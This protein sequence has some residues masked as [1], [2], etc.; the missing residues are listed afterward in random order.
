MRGSSFLRGRWHGRKSP[1]VYAAGSYSFG[2]APG[3][4]KASKLPRTEGGVK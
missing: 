1:H 2:A 3:A 4:A